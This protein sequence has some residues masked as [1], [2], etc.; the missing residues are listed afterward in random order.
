V[1]KAAPFSATVRWEITWS[2]HFN[3]LRGALIIVV[4]LAAVIMTAG[5]ILL[6]MRIFG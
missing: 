1:I 6:A 5:Y 2:D 3:M 4:S